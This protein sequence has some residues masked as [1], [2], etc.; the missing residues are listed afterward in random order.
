MGD[1]DRRQS[2]RRCTSGDTPSDPPMTNTT[3][4]PCMA[5]WRKKSASPGLSRYLPSMHSAAT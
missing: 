4:A 5:R 1:M 3:R 2:A